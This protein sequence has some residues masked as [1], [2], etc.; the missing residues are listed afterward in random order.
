MRLPLFKELLGWKLVAATHVKT[1]P[2][3]YA[4]SSRR[5]SVLR[6]K[7]HVMK[8]L[9]V[10]RAQR[11]GLCGAYFEDDLDFAKD[12]NSLIKPLIEQLQYADWSCTWWLSYGRF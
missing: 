4:L 1:F 9:N 6:P 2:G 11:L 10:L 12:F 7:G 8:P 3:H 5:A